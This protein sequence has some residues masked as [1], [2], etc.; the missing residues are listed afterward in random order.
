MLTSPHDRAS[1]KQDPLVRFLD[2]VRYFLSGWHI[3]PKVIFF[4]YIRVFT[5]NKETHVQVRV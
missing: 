2:V 3:K 1:T 5:S 4:L